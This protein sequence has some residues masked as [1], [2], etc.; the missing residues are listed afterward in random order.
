[1]EVA[2]VAG[3][4]ARLL[5]KLVSAIDKKRNQLDSLE[6]DAGFIQ[7]DLQSIQD[8]I[9]RSSGGSI[10]DLWIRDLRRLADDMEDC[11]DSF[12]VGKTTRI[13]FV[14]KIGKLKQRSKDTLEQLQNCISIAGAAAPP[15]A[16][17]SLAGATENPEEELVAL[18]EPNQSEEQEGKLKVISIAGFGGVAP[19]AYHK[20]MKTP[21]TVLVPPTTGLPDFSRLE[22]IDD[23]KTQELYDV[24]S[25][26][27]WADGVDGRIIMTTSIQLPAATCCRCG[28]G[29]PLA[30]DTTG[31][32]YIG[33]LT[34]SGFVEA[35]LH[36]RDDSLARMQRSNNEILSSPIVQDLL[37]Y[38]C[39]FPRDHPVRRNPLIRRW[40]AEGLFF[41]F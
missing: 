7:R 31:Q 13:S 12:Q 20:S 1:M 23:V 19:K 9:C 33:E 36:L 4:I 40:M 18:L 22:V 27:S 28:N 14:A 3:P 15:P 30:M 25:A 41:F 16:A 26:F 32:V 6:V 10:S 37:L 5:P 8:F 34:E 21:D 29:L 17:D 39:M 24:L 11:I 2:A 35:C 38:F